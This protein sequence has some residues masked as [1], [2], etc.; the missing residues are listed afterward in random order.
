MGN[1][2]IVAGLHSLPWVIVGDFNEMLDGEDKF[3]GRRVNLSR[4]MKF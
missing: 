3:R 1:L 2:S 4:A